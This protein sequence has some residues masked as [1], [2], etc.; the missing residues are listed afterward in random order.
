MYQQP[1]FLPAST[2]LA[3]SSN[4]SDETIVCLFRPN[5]G[6][7]TVALDMQLFHEMCESISARE[8]TMLNA[9]LL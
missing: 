2:A 8:K 5:S 3:M 9:N 6:L 1:S 7:F 4:C